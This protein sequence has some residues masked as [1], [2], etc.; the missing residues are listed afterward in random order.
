MRPRRRG[1]A[2]S[3]SAVFNEAEVIA[4]APEVNSAPE[5]LLIPVHARKKSRRKP[6]QQDLP[7]I[8]VIH[9]LPEEQKQCSHDGAVLQ[10]CRD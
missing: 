9:D 5:S 7:S 1:L 4:H 10:P 2:R 6:L 3:S 8:E